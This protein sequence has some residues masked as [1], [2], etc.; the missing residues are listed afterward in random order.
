MK[1]NMSNI[2]VLGALPN[3]EASLRLVLSDYE[4]EFRPK[5]SA[6]VLMKLDELP[7]LLIVASL[8]GQ[9]Q[10]IENLLERLARRPD[11]CRPSIILFTA[12]KGLKTTDPRVHLIPKPDIAALSAKVKQLLEK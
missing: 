1:D 7:P 5:N 4:L 12:T 3:I 10:Y 2:F 11:P 8:Q 9:R 6:S